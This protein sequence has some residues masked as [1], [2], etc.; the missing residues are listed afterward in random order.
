MSRRADTIAIIAATRKQLMGRNLTSNALKRIPAIQSDGGLKEFW[1][2]GCYL[3]L[4]LEE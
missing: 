3:R 4:L 1:E 2:L